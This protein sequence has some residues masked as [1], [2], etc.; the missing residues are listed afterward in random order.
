MEEK[1]KKNNSPHGL[2]PLFRLSG[3]FPGNVYQF[4]FN[5]LFIALIKYKM[6]VA[7][8]YNEHVELHLNK[9]LVGHVTPAR[10]S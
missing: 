5:F 3:S 10:L 7:E 4:Y 6:Y 2:T 1:D 9:L 8:I